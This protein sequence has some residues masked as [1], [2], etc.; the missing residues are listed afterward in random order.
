MVEGH[1]K[2]TKSKKRKKTTINGLQV[3]QTQLEIESSDY[4]SSD[5]TFLLVTETTGWIPLESARCD[6]SCPIHA[7]TQHVNSEHLVLDII[8]FNHQVII[9]K[10]EYYQNLN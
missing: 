3:C 2:K 9:F 10:S 8:T 6:L 1:D 5:G 7:I 4:S